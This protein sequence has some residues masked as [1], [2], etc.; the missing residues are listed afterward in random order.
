MWFEE[1]IKSEVVNAVKELYGVD[2][3]ANEIAT[4]QTK[5]DFEGD[6]TVVVFKLTKVSKQG[7]EQTANAIGEHLK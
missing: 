5:S 7:P 4:Q 3:S 1:E 6:L 2:L